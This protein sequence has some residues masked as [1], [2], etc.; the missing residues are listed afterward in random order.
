MRPARPPTGYVPSIPPTRTEVRPVKT[1]LNTPG[2]PVK[3]LKFSSLSIQDALV[4]HTFPGVSKGFQEW[5]TPLRYSRAP[6]RKRPAGSPGD[7][8]TA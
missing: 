8:L 6:G 4:Y 2:L 3:G 1:N 7:K 5:P